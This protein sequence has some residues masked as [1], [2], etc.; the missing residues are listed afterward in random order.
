MAQTPVVKNNWKDEL[1]LQPMILSQTNRER[2]PALKKRD[3]V[4]FIDKKKFL[5]AFFFVIKV[6]II[7]GCR[8]ARVACFVYI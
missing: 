2:L 5:K 7:K 8:P 1:L 4:Q 6:T 3:L